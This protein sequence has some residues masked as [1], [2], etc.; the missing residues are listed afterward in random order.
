MINWQISK[1]TTIALL[2]LGLAFPSHAFWG[3]SPK[4][5]ASVI[6]T[7]LKSQKTL[8]DAD[9]VLLSKITKQPCRTKIV[10]EKLGKI[11]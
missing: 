10:G 11:S 7:F 3:V 1:I 6:T 9:I 2:T 4:P 5:V 8:P